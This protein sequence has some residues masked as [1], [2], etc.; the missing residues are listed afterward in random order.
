[1][2]RKGIHKVIEKEQQKP[3]LK[4]LNLH[5]SLLGSDTIDYLKFSHAEFIIKMMSFMLGDC[6]LLPALINPINTLFSRYINI[7]FFFFSC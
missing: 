7:S 4:Y 5:S 2:L 1:M 3:K 6:D